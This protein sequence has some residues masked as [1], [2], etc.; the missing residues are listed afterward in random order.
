LENPVRFEREGSF[1]TLI[2]LVRWRALSDPQH[3]VFRF[4]VDGDDEQVVRSHAD[5]DR[6]ARAIATALRSRMDR[7]ARA[8]LLYPPG[9]EFLD[10]FFGCLYAGVV[11]VPAYPPE[12]TR[13]ERSVPRLR[14][15]IRDAKPTLVLTTSLGEM[16]AR[17]AS[18]ACTNLHGVNVSDT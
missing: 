4:L 17:G 13:M 10:A 11:A 1:P 18:E 9:L 14:A 16:L 7:G 6:R 8:L 12:P 5:L 15:I 2:D 3:A